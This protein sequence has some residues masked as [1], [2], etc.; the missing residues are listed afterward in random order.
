MILHTQI[1]AGYVLHKGTVQ[2]G[3]L[4]VGDSVTSR[5]GPLDRLCCSLPYL[6]QRYLVRRTRSSQH[7]CRPQAI[8]VSVEFGLQRCCL[9]FHS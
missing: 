4:H 5:C 6:G 2:G 3:V 9:G 7:S 1:A 8:S